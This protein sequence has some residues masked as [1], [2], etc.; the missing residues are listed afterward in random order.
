MCAFP[1]HPVNGRGKQKRRQHASLLD[2]CADIN[3]FWVAII[4]QTRVFWVLIE[5]FNYVDEFW[6]YSTF[7]SD[8]PQG[9][10]AYAIEGLLKIDNLDCEGRSAILGT[11]LLWFL[12]QWSGIYSFCPGKILPILLW[13]VCRFLSLI[14]HGSVLSNILSA[15]DSWVIPLRLLQSERSP[16]FGS[17]M[18]KP[19]FHSSDWSDSKISFIVSYSASLCLHLGLEAFT[20][21]PCFYLQFLYGKVEF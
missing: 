9:F 5:I 2:A 3:S 18:I 14:L 17:L 6:G 15:T 10:P 8:I 4:H 16:F 13:R 21:L 19:C 11:P 7:C 20:P 12:K 1:H